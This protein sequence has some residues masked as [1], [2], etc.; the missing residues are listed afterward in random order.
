LKFYDATFP[1]Y[2]NVRIIPQ[3]HKFIGVR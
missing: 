1:I 2:D 3:L